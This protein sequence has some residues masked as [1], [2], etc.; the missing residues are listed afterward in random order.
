[1]NPDPKAVG[2]VPPMTT[3]EPAVDVG[4]WRVRWFRT[5]TLVNS[6]LVAV[7]ACVAVLMSMR[8]GLEVTSWA[9][10]AFPVVGATLAMPWASVFVIGVAAGLSALNIVGFPHK[11]A[12]FLRAMTVWG[13]IVLGVPVVFTAFCGAMSALGAI[14]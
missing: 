8:M 9:F 2:P 4:L 11:G 10:V 12:R 3:E 6:A 14:F 13:T 7:S 1:M 5:L